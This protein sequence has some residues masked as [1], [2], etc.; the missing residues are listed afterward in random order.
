MGPMVVKGSNDALCM[1]FLFFTVT[2]HQQ[3]RWDLTNRPCSV[4]C[5]RAIRYSDF[6]RGPFRNG[7]VGDFLDTRDQ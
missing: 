2:I 1:A 4:S 3:L 6:F 7:P 5:D